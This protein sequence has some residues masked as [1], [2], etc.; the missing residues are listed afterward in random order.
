MVSKF[1]ENFRDGLKV[2][3]RCFHM[4]FYRDNR[5][6]ASHTKNGEKRKTSEEIM[7]RSWIGLQ[8]RSKVILH[9]AQQDFDTILSEVFLLSIFCMPGKTSVIRVMIF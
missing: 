9:H 2:F 1:S 5:G 8:P 6:F 3:F 4:I 7:S